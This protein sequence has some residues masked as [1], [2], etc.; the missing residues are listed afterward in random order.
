MKMYFLKSNLRYVTIA[1]DNGLAPNEPVRSWSTDAYMRH[2][3]PVNLTQGRN[4]D[5]FILF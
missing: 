4:I 1:S 5:V 2:S 3:A